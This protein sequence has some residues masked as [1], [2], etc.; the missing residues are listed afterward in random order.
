MLA[1]IYLHFLVAKMTK[2]KITMKATTGVPEF[3]AV[4]SQPEIEL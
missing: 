4:A 2:P 3:L 1:R